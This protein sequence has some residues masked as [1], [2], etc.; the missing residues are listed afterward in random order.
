M[1]F[2]KNKSGERMVLKHGDMELSSNRASPNHSVQI[3]ILHELNNPA[4]GASS[5]EPPEMSSQFS[6][7]RGQRNIF[8]Q[9]LD[10][11]SGRNCC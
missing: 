11:T 5:K 10:A 6:D 9:Y 8:T 4:L 2:Q 3:K 1:T 7:E